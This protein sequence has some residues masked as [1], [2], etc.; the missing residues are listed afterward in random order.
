[1]IVAI[2][3][4]NYLPW[5]GYFH[6]IFKTDV[7]VF[8]DNVDYTRG[9]CNRNRIKI[10]S[11]SMW[12]T[13]PV[14]RHGESRKIIDINIDNIRKWQAKHWN[15][16]KTNYGGIGH[17]DE[18]S[19]I[20]ESFYSKEWQKLSDMNIFIIEE[21][22][23]TLDLDK[24]TESKTDFVKASELK[25]EGTGTELL[26]NICKHLGAT[27]YFSG[28]AAKDYMD[29]GLFKEAGIKLTYQNIEYPR[30]KQ[31]FEPPFVPNLSIIDVLFNEGLKTKEI[32]KKL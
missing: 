6:K 12:L 19:G 5:I 16:I 7:F 27:E 10:K 13:V 26:V 14:K 1:M 32:I 28:L 21:I 8:L 18:F 11:G 30:Y 24:K 29:N 17:F 31:N 23:R 3:Q 25:I 22:A 2:H 20:F 15:A 4:P 9:F